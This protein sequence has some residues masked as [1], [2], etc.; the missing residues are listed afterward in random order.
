ME[1]ETGEL[2][3][4]GLVVWL[5]GCLERELKCVQVWVE[6]RGSGRQ[7]AALWSESVIEGSRGVLVVEFL[8]LRLEELI[9]GL[10]F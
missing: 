9:V 7:G 5:C 2:V 1:L 8:H 10:A 3:V 4:E 6:E